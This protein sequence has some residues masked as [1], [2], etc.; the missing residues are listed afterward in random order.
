MKE[1]RYMVQWKGCGEDEKTLEP[2]ECRKN[3]QE[4][5]DQFHRESL[6]M[7]GPADVE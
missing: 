2:P 7:L 4:E 5:V 6:K 1:L 3:G